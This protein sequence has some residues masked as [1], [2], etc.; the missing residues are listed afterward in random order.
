MEGLVLEEL[1]A[2]TALQA[3]SL[4]FLPGQEEFATPVTYVH[5][6]D[7]L[8]HTKTWSRVI[9]HG[10]DVV[11]VIRAHFDPD[12]SDEALRSCVWRVSVAAS[13]Q[14]QG[15]GR[16]AIHAASDQARAEGFS[17]LSVVWSPGEQGPGEF[18]HRLGF[19]DSGVTEYGDQIGT[20][21]L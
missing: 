4:E 18:F 15:V 19:R 10:D 5:A 21:G 3:N 16:F 12:H 1:S 13:A 14:G 20:L 6:D 17:S 7:T 8:D 11:G 2:S 9:L